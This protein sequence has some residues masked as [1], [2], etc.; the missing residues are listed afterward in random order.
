MWRQNRGLLWRPRRASGRLS[1]K[2]AQRV[3]TTEDEEQRP[4]ENDAMSDARNTP[5]NLPE[6]LPENPSAPP[7]ATTASGAG[8]AAGLGALDA[9]PTRGAADAP[10]ARDT[11]AANYPAPPAFADDEPTARLPRMLDDEPTALLP[12]IPAV[13]APVASTVSS[14]AD[15]IAD[16]T[17]AGTMALSALPVSSESAPA[18]M[19]APSAKGAR[20]F[21]WLDE[22]IPPLRLTPFQRPRRVKPLVWGGLAGAALLLLL[23][24]LLASVLWPALGLS[25]PFGG[26]PDRIPRGAQAWATATAVTPL[27]ADGASFGAQ[28]YPVDARLAA[29]YAAHGGQ[30]ALGAAVTPAFPCNLGLAQFFANGALLL[31][32]QT[33]TQ[34]RSSADAADHDLSPDLARDGDVDAT[35][36]VE[37]LPLSHALLTG[38]SAATIGG[39]N[40]GLTYARLRQ[41][42]LPVD[43]RAEPASVKSRIKPNAP[44][45]QIV[46][47]SGGAF[48]VE[49]ARG[50]KLVGHSIPAPIWSYINQVGIAPHG[51]QRDIGE[52]LTEPLTLTVTGSDGQPHH[53]LAQAFWQTIIISDLDAPQATSMQPIGLDYLHTFG[54]PTAYPTAGGRFWTTQDGALRTSPGAS[55]VA[56]SLNTN[57]AV[58]LTGAAQWSQGGLW[59]AVNWASPSRKGSA[60]IA[61]TALSATQLS[62]PTTAGFDALSP[63]LASYLSGLGDDVGAQVDDLTRNV[64][65][66][67]HPNKTFIM[68]SSA[69][70]PLMISYLTMIESQGRG[71]N[72]SELATL[73][74]MIERSDNNA[75]QLI[76]DTIGYGGGEEGYMRSW[77]ITDYTTNAAGWGWAMWSPADMAHL[78]SL[79][80]AGKV[81]NSSDRALAFH[82]MQSIESDQ[83]FGVGDTAPDNAT[84]AMKDGWVPGPDGSWWVNTSGIVTVGGEKYIITVYTGEQNSFGSGQNIVNHVCGAVAQTMV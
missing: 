82:L 39:A 45:P 3:A 48:V 38:G 21:G 41:A 47:Q 4:P 84:V 77:G 74:A 26:P 2:D 8:D 23:P 50:G 67:Y 20:G 51:W 80:Q 13:A 22:R 76:Y 58:T 15:S 30:S 16:S 55:A 62:G 18:P 70:V 57:A 44:L 73:T 37:W 49:G 1:G 12:G 56:V 10:G 9:P 34:A 17:E 7:P 33:P 64:V 63:S 32:S 14:I 40:S 36:H 35:T 81:L 5:E 43:L 28:T 79:L 66:T 65:Y 31:P 60:W 83:R 46:A 53:L 59:Y 6:N 29:G 11:A 25:S 78:L 42:T 27:A 69:K 24:A 68:A 75:A 72:S 54:A 19:P 52:P 71:P 61:P